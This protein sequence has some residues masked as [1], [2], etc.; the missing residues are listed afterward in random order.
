MRV[1]I[2]CTT[3]ETSL[4]MEGVWSSS[5][6]TLYRCSHCGAEC[7]VSDR[8]DI[9]RKVRTGAGGIPPANEYTAII[10]HS[11]GMILTAADEKFLKSLRI[12]WE[13]K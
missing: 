8:L 9:K 2:F 7:V 5:M 11:D 6:G 1:E 4:P 12:A 13:E 10:K 3:C